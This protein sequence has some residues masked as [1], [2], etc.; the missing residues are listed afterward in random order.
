MTRLRTACESAKRT[1][2]SAIH[3]TIEVDSLFEGED[4][5]LKIGRAKFENLCLEDFHKCME[6]VRRVLEDSKV[7]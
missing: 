5:Y 1:L 6:P 2:S 4:F 7:S 3:A